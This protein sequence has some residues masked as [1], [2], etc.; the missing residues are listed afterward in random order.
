MLAL[1]MNAQALFIRFHHLH[2]YRPSYVFPGH[3]STT[4]AC[5]ALACALSHCHPIYAS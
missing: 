2:F 4:T 1:E 5:Q 3:R